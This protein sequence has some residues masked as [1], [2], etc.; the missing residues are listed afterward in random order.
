MIWIIPHR[1]GNLKCNTHI[2]T[3]LGLNPTGAHG[4]HFGLG[5]VPANHGVGIFWESDNFC[6]SYRSGR[7]PSFGS[8]FSLKS[9]PISSDPSTKHLVPEGLTVQKGNK[10]QLY[11]REQNVIF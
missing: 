7:E 9:F 6:H 5:A 10:L 4:Y 8:H 11:L 3:L 1:P 2:Q